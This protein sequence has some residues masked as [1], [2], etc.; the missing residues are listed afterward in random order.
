MT[1]SIY[2]TL[3]PKYS[4]DV[5]SYTYFCGV[6]CWRHDV[7]G[8]PF[9]CRNFS[10]I[11]RKLFTCQINHIIDSINSKLLMMK[12]FENGSILDWDWNSFSFTFVEKMTNVA[13]ASSRQ[14]SDSRS[15][16]IL[17]PSPSHTVMKLYICYL[18]NI[19]CFAVR[20]FHE[21]LA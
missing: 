21:A 2:R 12:R 20:W 14:V 10:A 4:S 8:V 13:L 3:A 11:S 16:Y 18:N 17:E 6:L 15:F 7:T 9:R 1:K 5:A 19:P